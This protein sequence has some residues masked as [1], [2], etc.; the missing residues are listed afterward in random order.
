M[1]SP[2]EFNLLEDNKFSIL[3]PGLL[4]V[5]IKSGSIL[6]NFSALDASTSV[7]SFFITSITGGASK[8]EAE[9]FET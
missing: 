2:D 7:R 4:S 5:I 6:H 3:M 8:V 9:T 1:R